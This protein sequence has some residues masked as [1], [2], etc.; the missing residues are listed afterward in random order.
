MHLK[1]Q[2][3]PVPWGLRKGSAEHDEPAALDLQG[4]LALSIAEAAQAL[5]VSERHLRTHLSEIPHARIGGRVVVP[6]DAAREWLRD[7]ARCTHEASKKIV[8][9]IASDMLK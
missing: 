6:V 2:P 8:D 5:G 3:V 1:L 7:R 4:R 9:E